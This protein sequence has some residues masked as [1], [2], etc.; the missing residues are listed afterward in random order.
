MSQEQDSSDQRQWDS[1][2]EGHELAQLRRLAKL[3]FYEKLQW[4]EQAHALV[5]HLQQRR[6]SSRNA[7]D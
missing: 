3:S 6:E 1:G 2:W 7:E 5:L 4:L